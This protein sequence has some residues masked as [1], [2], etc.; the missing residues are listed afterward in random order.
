MIHRI[1][2]PAGHIGLKARPRRFKGSNSLGAVATIPKVAHIL[3]IAQQ[4]FGLELQDPMAAKRNQWPRLA[5]QELEH[6]LLCEDREAERMKGACLNVF[7]ARHSEIGELLDEIGGCRTRKGHS[8]DTSRVN[9]HL[10]QPRNTPL[11]RKRLS[12][13]R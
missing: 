1:A 10:E 4:G 9:I 8:Q 6:L 13:A 7:A 5:S 12:R 3:D 2:W 11:H